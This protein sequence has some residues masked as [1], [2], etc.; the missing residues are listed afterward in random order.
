MVAR[1]LLQQFVPST[2]HHTSLHPP[3]ATSHQALPTRSWFPVSRPPATSP[4]SLLN[5]HL[6]RAISCF[7]CKMRRASGHLPPVAIPLVHLCF[8]NISP[9]CSHHQLCKP[10]FVLPTAMVSYSHSNYVVFKN[11]HTC[12]SWPLHGVSPTST[13]A[14]SF[15]LVIVKPVSTPPTLFICPHLQEFPPRCLPCHHVHPLFSGPCPVLQRS[16]G[17]SQ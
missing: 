2:A 14:V 1:N 5:P 3:P 16:R 7:L 12:S 4:A 9:R 11:R 8:I 6:H 17:G 13:M 15:F 10:L